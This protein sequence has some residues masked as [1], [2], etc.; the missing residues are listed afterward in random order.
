MIEMSRGLAIHYQTAGDERRCHRNTSATDE[1]V[2]KMER[3]L[4]SA[5]MWVVYASNDLTRCKRY[6]VAE[7]ALNLRKICIEIFRKTSKI[8]EFI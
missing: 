2:S 7:N 1:N 4:N 6:L 3:A 5:R 8:E